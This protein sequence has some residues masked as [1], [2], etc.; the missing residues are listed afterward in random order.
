M[1]VLAETLTYCSPSCC[2]VSVL[3]IYLPC[4][5]IP[6]YLLDQLSVNFLLNCLDD[7]LQHKAKTNFSFDEFIQLVS[8]CTGSNALPSSSS[9]Q[10]VS[11]VHRVQ[12]ST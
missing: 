4:F 12:C 1:P 5:T 6:H 3:L 10:L 8:S 7:Y 2:V 11:S 9:F